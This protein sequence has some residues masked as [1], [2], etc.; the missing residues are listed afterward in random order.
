VSNLA[1]V[2]ALLAGVSMTVLAVGLKLAAPATPTG[3]SAFP[4]ADARK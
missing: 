2:Y 4:K 1:F 3:N